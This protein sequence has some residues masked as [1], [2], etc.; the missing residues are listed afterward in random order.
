MR[1][2]S[3]KAGHSGIFIAQRASAAKPMINTPAQVCMILQR[4]AKRRPMCRKVRAK[5]AYPADLI[6]GSFHPKEKNAP[7]RW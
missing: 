5:E 3:A 4:N 7:R 1:A 6:F 2:P